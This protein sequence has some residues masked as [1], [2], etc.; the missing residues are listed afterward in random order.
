M[1]RRRGCG[2]AMAPVTDGAGV[3]ATC[4]TAGL[5]RAAETA[6][7]SAGEAGAPWACLVLVVPK[8]LLLRRRAFG[9]SR[10]VAPAATSRATRTTPLRRGSDG[11]RA[12]SSVAAR[13]P[14]ARDDVPVD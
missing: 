12:S 11:E 2:P 13:K 8:L 3:R 7:A 14:K 9:E 4:G 1:V 5:G 10:P 6:G